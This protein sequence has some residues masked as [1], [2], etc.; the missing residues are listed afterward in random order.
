MVRCDGAGVNVKMLANAAS[1]DGHG[2]ISA[3]D[4]ARLMNQSNFL[5]TFSFT[6]ATINRGIGVFPKL[7]PMPGVKKFCEM[8][9]TKLDGSPSD[10]GVV[11]ARLVPGRG[12]FT[13]FDLLPRA[14]NWG[15]MC[16]KC[17]NVE[18]QPVYHKKDRTRCARTQNAVDLIDAEHELRNDLPN[19][20]PTRIR[21]EQVPRKKRKGGPAKLAENKM[22][23]SAVR[24]ALTDCSNMTLT[25]TSS[26]MSVEQSSKSR[27]WSKC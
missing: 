18:R 3:A 26:I 21:E 27:L 19:P 1:R 23:V 11:R 9:F 12:D 4:Y 25:S 2:P 24:A 20:D 7:K 8:V 6:F 5:H 16:G 15:R 17:S 22:H 13:V 14:K 10:V